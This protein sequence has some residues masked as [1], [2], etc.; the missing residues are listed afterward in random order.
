MLVPVFLRER[1]GEKIMPWNKGEASEVPNKLQL[2]SWKAI[3][4]S[5]YQVFFLTQLA[6][7]PLK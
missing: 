7:F 5:L 2:H 6:A 3:L 4:K 1:P